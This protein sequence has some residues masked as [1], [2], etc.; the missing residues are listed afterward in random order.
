MLETERFEQADEL[1]TIKNVPD[2]FELQIISLNDPLKNK[3]LEGIYESNGKFCTQC[4]AEG[5]RRITYAIDRPDNLSIYTV[6]LRADK[7]AY[8]YLLSNGNPVSSRDLDDGRHEAVWFDPFPKPSYL[9][10]LVAGDLARVEDTFTTMS[11]RTIDLHVYV[12]HGFEDQVPHCMTSLKKSMKWD[13]EV[14]GREYD[15]DL[16]QIVAVS[17]FNMGAMENKGLNVFNTKYVLAKKETATDND[18][19]G[20]E[21]VVGHEYFH[22]W[23]GNRVTCRDWFQLSLKEG[24]TVFRDQEFSA[25]MNWRGVQ[26]I[27]DVKVL[28]TGQFAEDA[29]PT[30]HPIRPEEYAEIS[31]FYTRTV[32]EKGAE[33]VRMEKTLVGAE[34]FRR[35]T[36]LYFDRFDGTAATC[37]DFVASLEEASSI[38]LTQFRNW[39]KQAGTPRVE[40]AR[41]YDAIEKKLTL[42]IKQETQAT[43]GQSEKAP[44][45]I[46]LRFALLSEDGAELAIQSSSRGIQDDVLILSEASQR[47]VFEKLEQEPVLSL[48]RDFSAPIYLSIDEPREHIIARVRF[49]P[50]LFNRWEALQTLGRDV[51]RQAYLG[52]E[53]ESPLL[54]SLFE[55]ILLNEALDDA[56]RAELLALPTE[57]EMMQIIDSVNPVRLHEARESLVREIGSQLAEQLFVVAHREADRDFDVSADAIGR[58]AFTNRCRAYLLAGKANEKALNGWYENVSTMTEEQVLL[59]A[60]AS[61][62][63]FKESNRV[64]SAFADKWQS[65]PLVMDKWFMLQATADHANVLGDVK[66]LMKHSGFDIKNPNKVRSLIGAFAMGNPAY[67]HAE[68]G[69]GYDFLAEQI[70]TVDDFNPQIASRLVTPLLSWRQ[71]DEGRQEMMKK[72]LVDIK[73]KPNLSKDVSEQVTR[74]LAS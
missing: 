11:G 55:E 29:G 51:I 36:D 24:F 65:D 72:A 37:E 2:A 42:E 28:R 47:F 10:A 22:N 17:D 38:D 1:L 14:F 19:L 49:D 59:S 68:N 9:F 57:K 74:G 66:R 50:D 63:D 58:R 31:N 35:G 30:A 39:Y 6:T 62:P 70:K 64:L 60:Y 45:V 43:P 3:A 21:G 69:E 4:E 15:L 25:D 32:Y 52:Q 73:S 13:E 27:R 48:N 46:P 5:F 61:H 53:T 26:R 34:N 54:I 20:I 12:E 40:V 44:F 71:F 18:F 41:S 56:S 67:F 33:V 8:P 7:K 23:S 16:F